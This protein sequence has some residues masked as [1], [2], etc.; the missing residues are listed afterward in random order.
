MTL[1]EENICVVQ[2]LNP[3]NRKPSRGQIILHSK[4]SVTAASTTSSI[5]T[6]NSLSSL[7]NDSSSLA[8][9]QS[10]HPGKLMFPLL[11]DKNS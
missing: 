1:A 8:L 3:D 9:V 7:R 2:K 4:L 6:A 10:T 5:V 11:E